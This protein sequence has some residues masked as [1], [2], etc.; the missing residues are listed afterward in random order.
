[1]S[2]MAPRPGGRPVVRGRYRWRG[3]GAEAR[4]RQADGV[5][6][7]ARSGRQGHGPEA[8]IARVVPGEHDSAHRERHDLRSR[9]A[10]HV[11]RGGVGDRQEA[12]VHAQA[13]DRPGR[14]GGLQGSGFRH[15]VRCE[16]RRPVLPVRGNGRVGD[17][18]VVAEGVRGSE[19]GE[20]RGPDRRGVRARSCGVTPRSPTSASSFA[21]TRNSPV[22]HSRSE[23]RFTT[24]RVPATGAGAG[25]FTPT[26]VRPG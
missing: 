22:S 13:G 15:R 1:M 5:G 7:L 9:S 23:E 20:A 11:A 10:R 3:R 24:T 8:E 18:E 14:T 17:R 16:E 2:I 4:P 26:P 21:T 25:T 12:L 19:P 6:T